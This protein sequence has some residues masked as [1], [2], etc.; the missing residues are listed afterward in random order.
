VTTK[1]ICELLKKYKVRKGQAARLEAEIRKL[2]AQLKQIRRESASALAGPGAQKIDGLP[3]GNRVS[4]P[5]AKA[6]ITL[7]E[8]APLSADENRLIEKISSKRAE[9]GEARLDVEYVEGWLSALMDREKLVVSMQLCD[10]R[11]WREVSQEYKE[12]FGDEMSEDTLRR[13]RDRAVELIR[14]M[15]L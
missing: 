11:T 7:A 15:M 13:M 4:D 12:R 1:E 6:G 10:G 14:R 9:L 5:T 2:D 8:G 3:R